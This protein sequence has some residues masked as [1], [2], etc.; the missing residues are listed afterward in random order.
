MSMSISPKAV[1]EVLQRKAGS[2]KELALQLENAI[3]QAMLDESIS[4]NGEGEVDELAGMVE[5][6]PLT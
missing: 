4:L 6:T 5:E 1:L 3:L 2:D